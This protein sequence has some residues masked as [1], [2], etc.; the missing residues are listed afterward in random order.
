MEGDIPEE[1]EEVEAEAL[2]EA[3]EITHLTVI[4]PE[5]N[6]QSKKT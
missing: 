5:I 3:G 2:A 6:I 4:R 1:E